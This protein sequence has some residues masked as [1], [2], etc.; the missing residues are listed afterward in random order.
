MRSISAYGSNS[1]F[2]WKK[3]IRKPQ[4]EYQIR[5]SIAS[6][7]VRECRRHTLGC[8]P[9]G[10][11]LQER[12]IRL[13]HH[14]IVS[15]ELLSHWEKQTFIASQHAWHPD[16]QT[17]PISTKH[18]NTVRLSTSFMN[19]SVCFLWCAQAS[20]T[21]WTPSRIEAWVAVLEVPPRF[22][23]LLR[24]CKLNMTIVKVE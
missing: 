4:V 6:Q 19:V 5:G 14:L 18:R 3:D 21:A 13:Y 10:L 1:S 23:F 22:I 17:L 9:Y 16:R 12:K 15:L 20:R 2:C 7:S 11:F 24:S 8:F